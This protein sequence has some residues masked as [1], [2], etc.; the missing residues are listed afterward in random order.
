MTKLKHTRIL[1]KC[2]LAREE[3]ALLAARLRRFPAVAAAEVQ[4][5]YVNLWHEGPLPADRVLAAVTRAVRAAEEAAVTPAQRLA[6]FRRDAL[7]SLASFA[8]MELLKRTAPELF[9]SMKVVRALVV[10]GISRHFIREGV[11]GLIRDREPN[12]DTL[13]TTAVLASVLAGNPESILKLLV[14]SNRAAMR[15]PDAAEKARPQR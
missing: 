1:M 4:G 14:H 12:A 3:S 15:T 9:A 8:A 11:T 7:I 2:A 13:T 6:A 5:G 10:L